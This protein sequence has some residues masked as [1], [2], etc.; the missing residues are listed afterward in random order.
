M[1]NGKNL[2]K[3]LAIAVIFLVTYSCF[4][5][6]VGEDPINYTPAREA[7]LLSEYL[8]TLVNREYDIDTTDLGVYYIVLEAGEGEFAQ[9]GDS[10]GIDYTGFFPENSSTFDA[11]SYHYEDG[12]WK[13]IHS[14]TGLI[15]GFYD[16]INHLNKGADVLFVLPSALA[17]GATGY[18]SIP[19]YTTIAFRI[20]LIDIY[21]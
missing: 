14:S 5:D 3:F 4:D 18:S 19:P 20:K 13:Y 17:Y 8:D 10:I 9:A 1:K 15:P 12:I 2:F 6:P 16:A 11:S 21:E 7:A